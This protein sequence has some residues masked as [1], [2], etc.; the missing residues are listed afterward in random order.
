[1]G[2]RRLFERHYPA[3]VRFLY[4]RLGDRDQA[5]ELAQ[6]AFTRLLDQRLRRPTAWLYAVAANLARDAARGEAVRAR[7][8]RLL[9]GELADATAPSPEQALLREETSQ[10]VRA[11]LLSLSERDR[12]LL[13]LREEGLT[14]REIADVIGISPT[15]VG[16]LLTRAQRRFVRLYHDATTEARMRRHLDG[17]LQA[18]LDRELGPARRLRLRMHLR[19]CAYC[20]GRYEAVARAN[21]DAARLLSWVGLT[22]DPAEAWGRFLVLSGRRAARPTIPTIARLLL[23]AGR[24][25]S[26]SRPTR[27][28][29]GHTRAPTCAP[30]TCSSGSGKP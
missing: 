6:E 27:P 5:E 18:L 22:V 30:R 7:R 26:P 2:I 28:G 8:L 23:P 21:A 17:D 3:V 25:R 14:Y 4:R 15:L 20:A 1:M 24:A 9:A 10:G 16:P 19:R 29:R 12:L 13:L 11:A